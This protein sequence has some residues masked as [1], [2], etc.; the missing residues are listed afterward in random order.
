ML[1]SLRLIS[2]NKPLIILEVNPS[3]LKAVGKGFLE[4]KLLMETLGCFGFWLDEREKL[5]G[6]MVMNHLTFNS[7]VPIM[8]KLHIRNQLGDYFYF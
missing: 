1:G 5:W 2:R 8:G 6:S 4:L 7:L 3:M